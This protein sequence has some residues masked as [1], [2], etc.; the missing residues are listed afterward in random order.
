MVITQKKYLI[1][2]VHDYNICIQV[3]Q[4]DDYTDW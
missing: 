1:F 4:K 2:I 3:K